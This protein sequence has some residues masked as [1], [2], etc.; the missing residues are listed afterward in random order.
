MLYDIGRIIGL[1]GSAFEIL[2]H[3]GE[4]HAV[5]YQEVYEMLEETDWILPRLSEAVYKPLGY[6][7]MR[8]RRQR[9]LA[10]WLYGELCRLRNDF[11]HGNPISE[12]RLIVTPAKRPLHFIAPLLYRMALSAFLKLRPKPTGLPIRNDDFIERLHAEME[13]RRYQRDIED[14]LL[15]VLSTKEELREKRRNS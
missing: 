13:P 8:P 11:L 5:G 6:K 4:G 3:P 9:I 14:G 12:T 15:T 7:V 1:W 10:V 2:S